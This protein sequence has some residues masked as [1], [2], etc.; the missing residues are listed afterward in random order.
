MLL[1]SVSVLVLFIFVLRATIS[2]EQLSAEQCSAQGFN[3]QI[4][5]C[6]TCD[7]VS[8]ILGESSSSFSVCKSCCIAETVKSEIKYKKAVLEVDK[9]TLPFSPEL[10]SVVD[11]KKD[12]KFQV[13][14]RYGTARLLMFAELGEDEPREILSVH[15]WNKDTFEDY[16]NTH[17]LRE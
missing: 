17:L 6:S 12:W 8:E 10:Q 9:R 5:Q 2:A 14:N 11:K 15:N 4:V 16:L 1:S 7:H 3:N 13:R